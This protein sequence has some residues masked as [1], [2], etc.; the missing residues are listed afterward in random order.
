M[1]FDHLMHWVPSLE[2]A[3]AQAAA[4][5]MRFEPAGQLGNGM[6]N[7]IWRARDLSCVELISVCDRAA[8]DK[9]PRRPGGSARDA[10]MMAGGG[11]LQ[12]AF[13]VDDLAPVVADVRSRGIEVSDP[14][15]GAIDQPNGVTHTWQAAWVNEGPGWRPFFIQYA[16][17]RDERLIRASPHGRQLAD[18]TFRRLDLE[19]PDP[20]A[21]SEW[22]AR[23]LGVEPGRLEGSTDRLT[24]LTDSITP[25]V[26][27]FGCRVRFLPG[28]SDRI[29]RIVL[30]GPDAPDAELAGVHYQRRAR[31]ASD[32][33]QSEP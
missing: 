16:A 10:A 9:R 26:P 27:A 5:G 21:A 3:I 20:D 29:I 15:V 25:E 31:P 7:A 33:P 18:W 8:W 22:L 6:H 2:A 24:G 12:F 28:P 19:T 4:V 30:D 1:Q 14:I 11:A 17:P 23:V 32:L 13:E